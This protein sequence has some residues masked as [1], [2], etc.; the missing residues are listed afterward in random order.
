MSQKIQY[1]DLTIVLEKIDMGWFS[2]SPTGDDSIY[3][4]DKDTAYFDLW[5]GEWFYDKKFKI[6][7]P[8][9]DK[10]DLYEKVI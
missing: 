6:E 4:T 1:S 5:T 8:E 9:F 7:E 10:I 3:I 2:M